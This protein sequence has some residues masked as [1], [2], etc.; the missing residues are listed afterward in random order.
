M[1][2]SDA[3]ASCALIAICFAI[4]WTIA[5]FTGLA[6]QSYHSVEVW[7]RIHRRCQWAMWTGGIGAVL[8]A[9]PLMLRAWIAV[10]L[11]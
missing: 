7:Q 4:V 2:Y 6:R 10:V 8:F 3:S 9:A 5:F 11:S 1:T